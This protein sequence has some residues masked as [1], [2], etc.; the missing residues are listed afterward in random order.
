MLNRLSRFCNQKGFLL[1][2]PRTKSYTYLPTLLRVWSNNILL[3]LYL[4]QTNRFCCRKS[5]LLSITVKCRYESPSL[6][7]LQSPANLL[8]FLFQWCVISIS[9]EACYVLVETIWF[10]LS[11]QC[12]STVRAL[13]CD[14]NCVYLKISKHI[15][16]C[17][18]GYAG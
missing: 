10:L 6:V 11:K 5:I 17:C 1:S 2:F 16:L 18:L 3:D 4:L 8:N 12:M 9:C 14:K 15:S 13:Y 7:S